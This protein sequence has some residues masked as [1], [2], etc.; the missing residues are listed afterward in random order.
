MRV[1]KQAVG[2]ITRYRYDGQMGIEDATGI[3]VTQYGL[4]ARGID[5]IYSASTMNGTWTG[6]PIYDAHGNMVATIARSGSNSFAVANQQSFD[7][8]G[9]TRIGSGSGCSQGYCANLGHKQ[10]AE[11]SLIYMRARYYEPASGRFINQD[12]GKRGTNFFAYASRN[13]VSLVDPSGT[14][15]ASDLLGTYLFGDLISALLDALSYRW[16]C[17]AWAEYGGVWCT[18]T[19]LPAGAVAAAIAATLYFAA[20]TVK[21]FVDMLGQLS[22][23]AGLSGHADDMLKLVD[24]LK[25]CSMTASLGYD[26][27]IYT[28]LGVDDSE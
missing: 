16:F 7:A 14:S 5:Y 25:G 19:I 3:G 23:Q 9:N 27:E 11:S 4:G 12:P 24:I 1:W 21:G 10:D 8:W 6:F 20:N 18:E 22:Y 2:S 13:P 26:L 17:S 28:W 15:S